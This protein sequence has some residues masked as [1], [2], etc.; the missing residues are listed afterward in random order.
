[1]KRISARWFASVS[2]IVTVAVAG[3]PLAGHAAPEVVA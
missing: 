2:L 1:M 3:T